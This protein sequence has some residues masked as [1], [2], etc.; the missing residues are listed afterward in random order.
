MEPRDFLLRVQSRLAGVREARELY[1][2]K[3]APDFNPLG[4]LWPDEGRLS[5]VLAD[6]LNPKGTHAQGAIFLEL[7]LKHFGLEEGFLPLAVHARISTEK[8]TDRLPNTMRRMDIF[9]DLGTGAITIENK[10]WA[11]DQKNQ[12]RD[13]LAQL[14]LSHP[15]RHCLLYLSASGN[16]PSV[17]SIPQVERE[18]AEAK[19]RVKVLAYP[20]LIEWLKDC[21]RES[22]SER[23]GA[24]LNEFADYIHKQFVRLEM[25]E[26]QKVVDIALET[27]QSLE[28]AL[29]IANANNEIRHR[30]LG[31]LEQQIRDKLPQGW[32]LEW[33]LTRND[34]WARYAGFRILCPE[35]T[36]YGV[37]FEFQSTQCAGLIY[38]IS[39]TNEALPG[40]P[41]VRHCLDRSIA[42]GKSNQWWP[43]YW[44]FKP[45]YWTW[46]TTVIPWLEIQDG[47]TM[48]EMIMA[49]TQTIYE[50]LREGGLL[51]QLG[52]PPGP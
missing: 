44:E 43:W 49:K 3:L 17:E 25:T 45:P 16:P 6:L 15:A 10:P 19:G 35:A 11:G 51:A 52:N 37:C 40:L 5:W 34:Y 26:L 36:L 14:A 30:L 4:L 46:A 41:D 21:R 1:A 28:A 2:A 29:E 20:Q 22:Q 24:F 31:T 7:F 23:V 42:V 33:G 18:A 12:C 13:Y 47:N 32:R 39:K 8:T 27:R 48:A 38:G 9:L 50:A